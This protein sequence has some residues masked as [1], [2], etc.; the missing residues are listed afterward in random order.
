M[1]QLKVKLILNHKITGNYWHLEFESG[2]IARLA[3]PGQF[4]NI[5]LTDGCEP[6][7]RRPISI[8][9]VKASKVGIMYEVLGK[10][11]QVLSAKQPGE[12]LDV[13]GPLGN[14]FTYSSA[15]T[16]PVLKKNILI[17]GGMGVAPLVFLAEKL[18]LSKPLVL[19]GA[20]SKKQLLCLPEFKAL[21]CTVKLA[22][23]DGSA[24][25]KGRVT[26]LLNLVLEQTEARGLF[27]CGP[28]PML[29]AVARIARENKITAQLSLEE[30]MACGIGACLG[31]VVATGAGYRSV[32]K[33]GPVFFSEEL[34]W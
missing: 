13:I 24:G 33:D 27:S 25:F 15:A 19:L 4:I 22:T 10:G 3:R 9:R 16:K 6:L 26:D 11:T 8:H 18:K 32:C 20:R 34:I 12:F 1:K 29:A 31:C 5:R 14:G 28:H 21:G 17:A 7:L 2:L 23:D 30:H